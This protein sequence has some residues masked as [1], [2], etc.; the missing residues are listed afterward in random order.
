MC[1]EVLGSVN[2]FTGSHEETLTNMQQDPPSQISS[3]SNSRQMN[4]INNENSN[5]HK[6][7]L[8]LKKEIVILKQPL[9]KTNDSWKTYSPYI[10]HSAL[11]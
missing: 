5:L 6:L 11:C 1:S 9:D 3:I 8:Q 2:A 10:M 7:I 4:K